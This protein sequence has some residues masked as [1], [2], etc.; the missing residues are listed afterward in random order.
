MYASLS[1]CQPAKLGKLRRG[2]R[3][4]SR[5][6][7]T[8]GELSSRLR[9]RG[10]P[11][12]MFRERGDDA[13]GRL[14]EAVNQLAESRFEFDPFSEQ[15]LSDP[16][17][18][19]KRARDAGRVFYSAPYDTHFV[20]RF[21]DVWNTLLIGDN[22]LVTTESVQPT[23][24]HLRSHHHD[25]APPFA[26]T[27]PMAPGT[28]LASPHQEELKHAHVAP[29]RPKSVAALADFVRN[30][31]RE[32]LD[33]LV[34]RGRF[35]LFLD[36]AA[37]VTARVM[38]HLFGLPMA[39]ADTVLGEV[40]EI[41]T[42]RPDNKE[43]DLG[44]F[45]VEIKPHILPAIEARRAAGA[46]G[47]NGLIDGLIRYRTEGRALTDLEIADQ[48]VCAMVGG[49]ESVPK[50]TTGGLYE[51]FRRPDQLAAVRA[52]LEA[53]APQAVEEMS[54]YCAPGTYLFRLAHKD[55]TIAGQPVRAG[56]RVALML[57][58]ALRDEREFEDPDSFVWNRPIPR[59]LTYG[60]GQH[61][62]IGKHLAVLELR[63]LVSEF[64]SRADK[65]EFL[66]AEG[67]RNTGYFQRGWNS[68]PVLVS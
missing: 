57:G 10:R 60:L 43:I 21:D 26:S 9:G 56:Q 2:L 13:R 66:E 22:T 33:E 63:I 12:P 67:D 37:V 65:V 61:Y 46:D 47:S 44:A 17:R 5:G 55:V 49:N 28:L 27:D 50:V 16:G 58:S 31:A 68:L 14:E 24:E 54:R 52:D 41:G 62:C 15:V 40:R 53:N 45:W 38:C 64:L 42:E 11:P 6:F 20:T 8:A 7:A 18:F 4:G 29:F 34:R 32:R 35:D 30:L 25:G 36:Y 23:P 19:Y 1:V 39:V 48:L 51:L 59:V 3:L